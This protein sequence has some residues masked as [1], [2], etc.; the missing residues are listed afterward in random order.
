MDID[1]DEE[2]G[3]RFMRFGTVWGQGAMRLDAPDRLELAYAVRMFAWLL[4]HEPESLS[5]QHPVTQGLG[6]G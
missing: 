3:V 2:D 1:I 6:A 5:A 4:F